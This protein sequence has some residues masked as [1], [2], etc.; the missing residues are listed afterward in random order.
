MAFAANTNSG[1]AFYRYGSTADF[2]IVNG[3]AKAVSPRT[4]DEINKYVEVVSAPTCTEDGVVILKCITS[5]PD[6]VA[7]DE[8][9]T[10][11]IDAGHSWGATTVD[12]TIDEYAAQLVAQKDM[13]EAEAKAWAKNNKK[14]KCHVSAKRCTICGKVKDDA[15]IDHAYTGANTCASKVQCSYTGCAVMIDTPAGKQTGSHNFTGVADTNKT[16]ACGGVITSGKV[17][18][19]CGEFVPNSTVGNVQNSVK[20][21]TFVGD[22]PAGSVTK[23][24]DGTKVFYNGKKIASISGTTVT[25][26][27]GY[28]YD[29][30]RDVFI[31]ADTV[32]KVASVDK[33]GYTCS[34]CG[35]VQALGDVNATATPCSH[36]WSKVTVDATC[37]A[38]AKEYMVCTECGQYKK[39]SDPDTTVQ[40]SKAA[41]TT[42][43]TGS[44]ALGHALEVKE[45]AGDC[46]D[47]AKYVVKCTRCLGDFD[48]TA[49][50]FKTLPEG[51]SLYVNPSATTLSVAGAVS[52]V[53]IVGSAELKYL[54]TA[55][56]DDHKFTKKVTVKAATCEN[57]EIVT[58]V[59]DTC[60]KLNVH[61][62]T[63]VPGTKLAHEIEKVETPAT[64]EMTAG[65]VEKC[66]N[67][68]YEKVLVKAEP[69]K[70]GKHTGEVWRVTKKAT[71]FEEGVK[72]LV[73]PACGVELGAKT[74][75]SKAKYAAPAVK[76]G[77][78]SATVTVKATADAVSYKI[79]YKKAG[80]S[81]KT[82]A[83]QAGKK[84]IKK[85]AKGKKYTFKVIAVNAEGVEVD[86]ATKTVKV[87]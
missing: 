49:S 66:K 4:Q 72:T 31:K 35:Y 6:G 2:T 53:N 17:C 13:T 38:P 47:T 56:T 58:Y 63:I 79:S 25:C 76:A 41:A 10:V 87:K 14:T 55:T 15:L 74:P 46:H 54:S 24:I 16:E 37:V 40:A 33:Y 80:G 61:T 69:I 5:L 23:S 30:E 12:M 44:K 39:V 43:V 36:A 22:I 1:H 45:V 83:A 48:V 7:C 64:C 60:G 28:Y 82:V 18:S 8:T 68:D 9:K 57:N 51:T 11:T 67:C 75:T 71:V 65:S 52:T 20:C 84:T 34:K 27:A 85:L 59:C 3:E 81:Y 77:K 86:S 70:G 73:C 78:K 19:D 62:S 26:E 29:A 32:K 50:N 21:N 42:E